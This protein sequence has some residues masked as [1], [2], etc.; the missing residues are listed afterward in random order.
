MRIYKI[1]SAVIIS[2]LWLGSCLSVPE[3]SHTPEIEFSGIAISPRL[4]A[5]TGGYKDSITISIKFKDGDGDLGASAED[6]ALN[7]P[8]NFVL[9]QFRK[10]NGDFV[11]YVPADTSSVLTGGYFHRLS[12]EKPGPIEGTIHH[13][14]E[15]LHCCYKY[16]KDTI[17]FEVFIRDRAGNISNT[18]TTDP[19]IVRK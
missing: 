4:D 2:S 12:G 6:I 18:V 9:K 8:H 7:P 14:V 5:N 19:V 17:R 16:A 1:I 11:P 15:I 13:R 3:F 10:V